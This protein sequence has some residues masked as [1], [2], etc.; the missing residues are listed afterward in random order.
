MM[1]I[2]VGLGNPGAKYA[3]NRHNIGF[4]AMDR[5]AEDHNFS[6]WREK[7]QGQVCKGRVGTHD[8]H[9]LKPQTYMNNS[10]QS[11]GE[12][13]RFFKLVP[14][15]IIVFHDELDLGVG[16]VRFKKGGGH[17]GHNGLKSIHRHIGDTYQRA[18]VGIGHPGRKDLVS[19]YVLS[20]FSKTD[21][22]TLHNVLHGISKGV[23]QLVDGDSI[24]FMNIVSQHSTVRISDSNK[25]SH[26]TT[27]SGKSPNNNTLRQILKGLGRRNR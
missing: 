16:K 2:L 10:G 24:K 19:H 8:L 15:K 14:N 7:F 13:M 18:R 17:A 20:D 3:K 9:L 27:E 12:V 23:A 11:V 6:P 5:I 1:Q 21:Q 22:D 26:N 25:N 4:M